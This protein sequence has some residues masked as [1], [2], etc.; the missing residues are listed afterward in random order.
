MNLA[1]IILFLGAA[2][3]FGSFIRAAFTF[4]EFKDPPTRQVKILSGLTLASQAA[5]LLAT[6]FGRVEWD[7]FF[8]IG[9]AIILLSSTLFW[10]CIQ[11][12]SEKKLTAAYD[13]NSPE[14]LMKKGPYALIRHPFYTSYMLTYIGGALGSKLWWALIP[15]I[16]P[17]FVYYHAS[18][19]EERKFSQSGL[20]QAYLEYKKQAGRFL[21]RLFR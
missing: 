13:S 6:L 21:P 12:N 17:I 5:I 19:F 1:N 9:M 10:W 3:N 16:I 20:H 2:F 8:F 11:V 18:N 7:L 4:F 14:H 15:V